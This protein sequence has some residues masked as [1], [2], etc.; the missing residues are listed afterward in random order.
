[1]ATWC[2]WESARAPLSAAR[3][4]VL[5]ALRQRAH[6]SVRYVCASSG[7]A[8]R[9]QPTPRTPSPPR[10]ARIPARRARQNRRLG[11]GSKLMPSAHTALQEG[12]VDWADR[13]LSG[14]QQN[15]TP[16]FPLDLLRDLKLSED[17]PMMHC[18][19]LSTSGAAA[20]ANGALCTAGRGWS[21]PET[22]RKVASA[23]RPSVR[24]PGLERRAPA[25]GE[26]FSRRRA[27]GGSPIA[28]LPLP[29]LR[30]FVTNS[31]RA[32]RL[33]RRRW[34]AKASERP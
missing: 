22:V 18:G 30:S 24:P 1:M 26:L 2:R 3:R 28:R 11:A 6:Y 25:T 15:F 31:S 16:V 10:R 29:S 12:Q 20:T 17:G 4:D 13:P 14:S 33:Q 21:S 34:A 7:E 23:L 8:G 32:W 27:A 5:S 9:A 19:A